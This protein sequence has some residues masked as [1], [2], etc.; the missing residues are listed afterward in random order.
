MKNEIIFILVCCLSITPVLSVSVDSVEELNTALDNCSY[1]F[2]E[3]GT[4]YIDHID[5]KDNT[6]VE[7]KNNVLFKKIN[8]TNGYGIGINGNN[9]VLEG[10]KYDGNGFNCPYS[11][12]GIR[13]NGDNIKV[14][15]VK[16][17][18]TVHHGITSVSGSDMVSVQ[19]CI[20]DQTGITDTQDGAGII[21]NGKNCIVNNNFVSNTAYH[22]IQAYTNSE[23]C[24]ITGN[25][26]N[27]CGYNLRVGGSGGAGIK[28][29]LNTKEIIING[30]VV[31]NQGGEGIL[32][33]SANNISITDNIITNATRNIYI[34]NS[35]DI[36]CMGN[37][38]KNA[39]SEGI[40]SYGSGNVIIQ[41]NIIKNSSVKT[42]GSYDNLISLNSLYTLYNSGDNTVINNYK[43]GVFTP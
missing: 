16:V 14:D 20:V 26:I 28:A 35:N 3:E 13:I 41:G 4:Y 10:V 17:N 36:N 15:G 22:G 39:R 12:H 11:D 29:S 32:S 30:N 7:G 9:I 21:V 37:I 23:K 8:G 24:I 27:N 5:I 42:Y 19:N 38:V 6:Y 40:Y 2:I 18:N 34:K 31:Y 33:D 25:L 43:M 1:I